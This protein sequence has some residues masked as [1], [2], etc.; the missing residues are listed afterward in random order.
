MIAPMNNELYTRV[1]FSNVPE[2][3]VNLAEE[4]FERINER[5]NSEEFGVDVKNEWHI[6][7][8]DLN[9]NGKFTI[10]GKHIISNCVDIVR[11]IAAHAEKV[12]CVCG[13]SGA[14]Q[15]SFPGAKLPLCKRHLNIANA[16]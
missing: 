4:L 10:S 9:A 5:L 11:E 14:I 16:Q 8:I 3:W 13:E 12:C 1:N 7:S 2:G 15:Q 6:S